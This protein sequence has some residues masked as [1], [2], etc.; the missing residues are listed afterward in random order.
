MGRCGSSADSARVK[1]T[2]MFM[3][4]ARLC[5]PFCLSE[6]EYVDIHD[7]LKANLRPS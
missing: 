7:T 3:R 1:N 2:T 5:A 4:D 6:V